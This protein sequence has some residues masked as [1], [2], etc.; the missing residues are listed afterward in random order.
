MDKTKKKLQEKQSIF[1]M[2]GEQH[3]DNMLQ[4][5]PWVWSVDKNIFRITGNNMKIMLKAKWEFQAQREFQ[6]KFLSNGTDSINPLRK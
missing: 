1:W 3:V 6:R 2:S 4:S 5:V